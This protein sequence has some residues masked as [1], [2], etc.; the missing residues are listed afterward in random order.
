MTSLQIGVGDAFPDIA[1]FDQDGRPRSV[2]SFGAAGTMDRYLGFDEGLPTIVVFFRGPFCP[3]D[4][5]QLRA[6]MSVQDEFALSGCGIVS[7]SVQAREVQA[8]FRFGLGAKWPFL[9]DPDRSLIGLLGLVDATEGE[10][11][12]VSRPVT[13]VLDGAGRVYSMYDGWFFVSRP[14]VEE[15]RH[16]V[17][18]IMATTARYPYEAWTTERVTSVRVPQQRWLEPDSGV[19]DRTG[20][21]AWFD[22][23]K[24][25]GGIRPDGLPDDDGPE[26]DAPDEET[27]VFFSFSAIPGSGYRTVRAGARVAFELVDNPFGP[28]ASWV[29]VLETVGP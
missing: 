20:R 13:F 22:L 9:A 10:E 6:L 11:A 23:A 8:A 26:V 1:L 29:V 28:V 21:V 7:V 19:P 17:R 24:G 15:L 5:A 25:V 12:F 4:Q 27:E 3:R 18:A 14:T 2:H 16:D